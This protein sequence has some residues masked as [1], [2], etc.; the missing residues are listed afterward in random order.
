MTTEQKTMKTAF[1]AQRFSGFAFDPTVLVIAG[2]DTDDGA[3]HPLVHRESNGTSDADLETLVRSIMAQ[4]FL[5]T[6]TIAKLGG[7][8][9]VV[10]G[11]RR[12]R[13]ARIA[14]SRLVEA[15][16]PPV[17]VKA[18]QY[19]PGAD[20]DKDLLGAVIVSN[21]HRRSLS[22]I[23]RARQAARLQQLGASLDE[24]AVVFGVTSQAVRAWNDL[25]TLA[26]AVQAK[27]ASGEIKA[28]AA[29]AVKGMSDADQVAT[30]SSLMAS[31]GKTT[32]AEVAKAARAKSNGSMKIAAPPAVMVGKKDVRRA[33]DRYDLPAGVVAVLEWVMG[34]RTES[35]AFAHFNL[36]PDVVA[37]TPA[38]RRGK[39]A[40]PADE[41]F[42]IDDA[43]EA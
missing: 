19:Q 15:G 17:V 20:R 23:E 4:G 33:M 34:E 6:V 39:K 8:P 27:V 43:P 37:A 36:R 12:T 1:D 14:S 29:R 24:V 11:R 7:R 22:P 32:G 3:D 40:T 30:I 10:E 41:G 13:A 35:E 9:Y 25:L 28:S 16:R 2:L 26:P 21:E 42:S 5:G 38:K 31:G 18:V